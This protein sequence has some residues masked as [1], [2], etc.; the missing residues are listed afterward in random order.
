MIY[1]YIINIIFIDDC[2]CWASNILFASNIINKTSKWGR[3]IVPYIMPDFRS[4]NIDEPID[5]IYC[6][7]K[8][9]NVR[10]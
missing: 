7:L 4:I 8:L 3:K 9:K 2:E 5:L 6:K 10:I 1:F